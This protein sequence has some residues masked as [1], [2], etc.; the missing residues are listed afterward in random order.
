MGIFQLRKRPCSHPTSGMAASDR[1]GFDRE[2]EG[3][4]D[5]L[6]RRTDRVILGVAIR[7]LREDAGY[8][9]GDMASQL[10]IPQSVLS[11]IESAQREVTYLELRAIC[12]VVNVSVGDFVA[13]LEA[14]LVNP[15]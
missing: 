11:K 6:V 5:H 7:A 13:D 3:A 8:Q 4:F 9:Q 12:A 1:S 10:G 15:S 14:L 2:R